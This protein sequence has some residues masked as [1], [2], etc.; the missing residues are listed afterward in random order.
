[1]VESQFS[2]LM[3]AGSS[4]VVRSRVVGTPSPK[5]VRHRLVMYSASFDVVYKNARLS[6]AVVD[7]DKSHI[8]MG[9]WRNGSA[10][11]LHGEG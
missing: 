7:R 5:G 4:P 9:L 6:A 2:K 11:P 8:Y 10:T 3:V 1:M